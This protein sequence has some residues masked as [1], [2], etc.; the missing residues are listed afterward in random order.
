MFGP[1]DELRLKAQERIDDLHARGMSDAK[2]YDPQHTNVGGIHAFFLVRGSEKAYNLP[3]SPEVPT[4]YL[5]KGWTA[6]AIGSA[7]LVAGA[8]LAFL[9]GGRS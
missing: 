9:V 2:I 7:I 4:K 1:L 8:A 3:P 6:S 5:K